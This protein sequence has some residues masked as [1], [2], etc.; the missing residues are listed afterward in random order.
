MRL[1]ADVVV[2]YTQYVSKDTHEVA[3]VLAEQYH[4]FADAYNNGEP[5]AVYCK[6]KTSTMVDMTDK[7]LD[8]LGSKPNE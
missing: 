8:M 5:S 3:V 7:V 2:K 4:E 6:L 1:K